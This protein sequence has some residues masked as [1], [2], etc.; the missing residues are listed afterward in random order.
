MPND[1]TPIPNAVLDRVLPT[2]ALTEVPVLLYLFRRAFATQRPTVAVSLLQMQRRTG[3]A[4]TTL[5]RSLRSLDQ[6]GLITRQR[7]LGPNGHRIASAYTLT[8]AWR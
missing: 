6:R 7:R 4:H 2:L 3:L 1:T 8:G 5:L